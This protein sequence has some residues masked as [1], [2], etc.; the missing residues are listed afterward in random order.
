MEVTR[1]AGDFV[2]ARPVDPV[3]ST[4]RRGE[5][6]ERRANWEGLYFADHLESES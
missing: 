4:N 6:V 3:V 1:L 5:R 2:W